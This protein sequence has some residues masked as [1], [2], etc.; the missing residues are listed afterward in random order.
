MTSR[1]KIGI[2]GCGVIG[3]AHVQSYQAVSEADLVAVSDVNAVR[4]R[5]IQN[6]YNIPR[7]YLR[8]DEMLKQEPL[9]GVVIA[10]PDP[11][12]RA[13]AQ[14]VAAAGVPMFLEKPIATTLEDSLA[15]I[16]AFEGAQVQAAMGFVL[17][18]VSRY[19]VIKERFDSG[20]LGIPHTAYAA[21]YLN[22]SEAR[23]F[24][25]RCSVNQ[26]IACHDLDFLMW[27]MGPEVESVYAVRSQSRAFQETGEA[28]SYL[29]LVRW[30]NGAVAS[31]LITWGL[32]EAFSIVEDECLIIGSKGVA[33][34]DSK[35]YGASPQ[36]GRLR[37]ATD[38]NMEAFGFEP[39]DMPAFQDQAQAFVD[40]I[41]GRA[42]P[43][44]TLTDGL[45]AQILTLAAEESIR[46]GQPAPVQI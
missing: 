45:R 2:I 43:R 42:Q 1:V 23:R 16:N 6:Q 24:K 46:T 8:D 17:R 14:A 9:D 22:I 38:Q 13:P 37:V 20:E 15:I 33:D 34:T 31:V 4:L 27:V 5:E 40:V 19:K 36:P 3:E 29:N 41:Q 39:D 32:P 18:F 44:A 11:L 12:H 10:T 26:Y 35:A 25:A 28:D 7:C 21:R 30:K